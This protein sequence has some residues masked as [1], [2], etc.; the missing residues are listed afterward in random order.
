MNRVLFLLAT[1]AFE[2]VT[3]QHACYAYLTQ[4]QRPQTAT[5]I[6]STAQQQSNIETESS[7][8]KTI[9]S[10]QEQYAFRETSSMEEDGNTK[11]KCV[12]PDDDDDDTEDDEELLLEDSLE[13]VFATMGSIWSLSS[14]TTNIAAA[15]E[16]TR[17]Q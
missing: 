10:L 15:V 13:M 3:L 6:M 4:Q 12:C 8:E 9:I 1:I 16:A 14:S 11:K 7:S 5:P 17:Q 2:A